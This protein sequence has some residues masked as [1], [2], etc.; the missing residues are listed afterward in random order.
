MK[1]LTLLIVLALFIQATTSSQPC[2]PEGIIFTTQA[3]IDN[4]QTNYP[5]CTEI[6]GDVEIIGNDITNLNGL[7]VLT[8]FGGYLSIGNFYI[9]NPVLASLTGLNNV[10]S[11]GGYLCIGHNTCLTNLSDL[12]NLTFIG[13]DIVIRSNDAL[14]SLTGLENIT[15]I[16]GDLIIGDYFFGGN[17][18][19]TSLTGLDNV[20]SIVGDL[21]IGYNDS[22]TSLT[23]LD[24]VTSIGGYL[25]IYNNNDLTSLMSL[26]NV[27]SIGGYLDIYGNAVLTSLSGLDNMTSIGEDLV[28]LNNDALT[29]LMGLDNVTFIGKNLWVRNNSTLTSLTGLDNVTSIGGDLEIFNN[30]T[31]TSLT[32]LHNI[33]AGSISNLYIIDNS[34]LSTCDVKSVCDYLVDPNGNISIYNNAI[35][36]NSQEEVEEACGVGWV[37]K[38]N[39]ESTFSIYPN[40]AKKELFISSKNG[41]FIKEVNIY[42]QVGQ[43]VLHKKRITRTIDVSKLH[44]GMYII[45]LVL[46]ESKI[47]EKLI[48]R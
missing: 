35:G 29:S 1:K 6:E 17:S 31:L 19:L 32:G 22:L 28:I 46:N 48:I 3:Q 2:L 20:I 34:L 8:S 45:E 7:N 13:G 24:N 42:N 10:T 5:N 4:F 44:Q 43:I 41:I 9:G 23:G 21:E 30:A 40:P 39:F 11:I 14:A 47:R 27:T 38:I 36:C 33:D 12:D 15:S 18:S 16:E 26:N 25:D 37:P